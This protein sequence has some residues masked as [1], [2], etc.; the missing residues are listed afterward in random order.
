[1]LLSS[2]SVA[3]SAGARQQFSGLAWTSAKSS[4]FRTSGCSRNHANLSSP[5]AERVADAISRIAAHRAAGAEDW[6]AKSS[7]ESGRTSISSL[8]PITPCQPRSTNVINNLDR[9]GSGVGQITSVKHQ[10]WR[11]LPEM[12][13][14]RLKCS[15]IPMNVG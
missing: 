15:E 13:K 1:M 8:L 2:A 6:L 11:C 7:N 3:S 14:H 4:C 5:R 12:R 10:V 9:A